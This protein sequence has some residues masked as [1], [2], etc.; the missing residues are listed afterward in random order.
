MSELLDKEF[1][2]EVEGRRYVLRPE[3]VWVIQPK[4]KPGVVIGL[5]KTPDGK[6]VARV[7]ARLPP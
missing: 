1:E 4:E 3:K 7:I 5:F 6:T 2:V